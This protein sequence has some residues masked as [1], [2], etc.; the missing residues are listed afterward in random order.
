MMLKASEYLL[1]GL[2]ICIVIIVASAHILG[3][4]IKLAILIIVS[5]I[6][7]GFVAYLTKGLNKKV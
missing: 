1:L 4:A 7:I 6:I 3:F 2:L 5:L